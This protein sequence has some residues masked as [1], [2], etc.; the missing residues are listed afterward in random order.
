MQSILL[1]FESIDLDEITSGNSAVA[2]MKRCDTKFVFPR[3]VLPQILEELSSS[4][5]VLEI[6]DK[7]NF[8]YKNIYFDTPTSLFY[9]QH[10]NKKLNRHKVRFRTY[11]DS[12]LTLF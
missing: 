9:L 10:H 3:E 5:R 1:K 11:V 4:Y 2:L 8:A 12:D 7:R 6:N